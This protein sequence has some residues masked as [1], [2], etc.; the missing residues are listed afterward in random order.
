MGLHRGMYSST[1]DSENDQKSGYLAIL[2][3]NVCSRA[4]DYRKYAPDS[5]NHVYIKIQ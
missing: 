2:R 3:K 5:T 1:S 4:I